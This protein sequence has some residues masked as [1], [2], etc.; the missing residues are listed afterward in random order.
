MKKKILIA[1]IVVMGLTGV[2]FGII[3]MTTQDKPLSPKELLDLG[4]KYLL[5]M[6]YEQALV[7]FDKVIEV[8]PMNPRGYTGAA[9]AYIGLEK[10][11]EAILI[12]EQG[13]EITRESSIKEMLLELGVGE[14]ELNAYNS[15]Q[16][17]EDTSS[18]TLQTE[19]RTDMKNLLKVA[20]ENSKLIDYDSINY[21]GY[22]DL[23]LSIHEMKE[24]AEKQG[25]SISTNEGWGDNYWWFTASTDMF[26][27]P[28]FSVLQNFDSNYANIFEYTCYN[29]GDYTE[30]EIGVGNILSHE[31]ISSFLE[32]W[33]F[34]NAEE[35][36][37]YLLSLYNIPLDEIGDL[38]YSSETIDNYNVKFYINPMF[39]DDTQCE[40]R[41]LF[42][43]IPLNLPISEPYHKLEF[44]F[45][46]NYLTDYTI[47]LH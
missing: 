22:S 34:S 42:E 20:S 9:E 26:G 45:S 10:L 4:E 18:S 41:F 12:L 43:F 31:H 23:D 3:F 24:I 44:Q 7:C 47:F 14:S 40:G 15:Q 1:I 8:E 33:G 32:K 28:S 46:D 11:E 37:E 35:I 27:G 2:L 6:N 17:G 30:M 16:N 19:E 5:E 21:L 29:I 36:S 38:D 13:Y 25:Y 39:I